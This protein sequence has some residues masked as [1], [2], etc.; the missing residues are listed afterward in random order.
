[1]VFDIRGKRKGVVKVVYAVLALLMGASL[2]LVT[3]AG[4]VAD[5]FGGGGSVSPSSA[6]EDQ[7]ANI[8]RKLKKEPE[9]EVLLGALFRTRVN[10]GNANIVVDPRTQQQEVS[11]Q[12]VTQFQRAA[13]A[14]DEYLEQ[15]GDK[16]SPSLA[17]LAAGAFFASAA[18]S[19]VSTRTLPELEAAAEAQQIVADARPT[20]ASLSSLAV[21]QTYAFRFAA[22]EKS[23]KRAAKLT[24]SKAQATS[25]GKQLDEV[26][27]QAKQFQK[28]QKEFT[29]TTQGAGKEVLENPLGGIGGTAMPSGG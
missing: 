19:N 1:M 23:E 4:S 21:Y 22:A 10:A 27:K 13:N 24:T 11:P 16:P 28:V 3:G 9:N 25:L 6:L 12:A 20:L 17:Q 14:W 29:E 8:E 5:L 26:R 7:A 2:F 18:N 15:A